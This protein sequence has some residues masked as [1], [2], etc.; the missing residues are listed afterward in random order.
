MERY[1]ASPEVVDWRTPSVLALAL[2]LTAGIELDVDKGRV[3]FEWVRDGVPHTKDI[4]ASVV[5]CSASEVLREKTGICYAKSHLLAALLRANGIPT[6]FCYQV[7][8]REA[9]YAGR[10]LHA[11]NGIFLASRGRWFRVDCRG[12]KPGV[13]AQFN[14]DTEQIAFPEEAYFDDVVYPEQFP[15]VI[16]ALRTARDCSHLWELLPDGA[17]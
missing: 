3:L 6:G 8:D 14:L 10:G 17:E 9:P 11:L 12:N 1:L 7:F 5:T 4:G 15:S 2:E 13:D 16:R